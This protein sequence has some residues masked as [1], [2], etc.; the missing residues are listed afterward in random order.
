MPKISIIIPVYNAEPYLV[1]CLESAVQQ[2]E[3]DIEIVC[4]DDCSTDNSINTLYNYKKLDERITVIACKE[5][6]G[7]S[8][9]RNI[10]V[11]HATGEY[12][13]F[14]DNDD[15]LSTDFC[16]LLYSSAKEKNADIVKGRVKTVNYDGK[17]NYS[18][19]QI[20]QRISTESKFFFADY[21]WSAIYKRSLIRE[22]IAFQ[23]GYP[24]GGDVLFLFR[25]VMAAHDI[26]CIN[27]VVYHHYLRADSGCSLAL[28]D[29]KI[30]SSLEIIKIIIFQLN[31]GHVFSKDEP[32]YVYT[33][34]FNI[35]KLINTLYRAKTIASQKACCKLMLELYDSC[36]AKNLLRNSLLAEIPP[37]VEF[38]DQGDLIGLES[39]LK[40][41]S[42]VY[43]FAM[44]ILRYRVKRPSAN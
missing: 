3:R 16:H 28:A 44:M 43:D 21:W 12:L 24:L 11:A 9:A 4:V 2:T 25:A 8:K 10:G 1:R 27:N 39:F 31:A 30:S 29:E 33:Y 19:P 36:C 23:E 42:S 15:T 13:A 6:G 17:I 5:N 38:F 26:L 40:Q 37:V 14:L 18:S 35:Q 34:A 20:H 32:G 41:Y 22:S 7:E